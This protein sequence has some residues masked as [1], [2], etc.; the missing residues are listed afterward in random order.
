M[1]HTS[2]SRFWAF[3]RALLVGIRN[4]TLAVAAL[5]YRYS[6]DFRKFR[7]DKCGPEMRRVARTAP[8]LCLLYKSREAPSSEGNPSPLFFGAQMDF[9]GSSTPL[10]K[11]QRGIKRGL[12]VQHEASRGRIFLGDPGPHDETKWTLETSHEPKSLRKCSTKI[13]FE[14]EGLWTHSRICSQV[15]T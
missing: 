15:A 5:R 6:Q 10:A 3:C 4:K 12:C 8:V 13:D 14:R 2:L 7:G 11:C 9:Y 1:L